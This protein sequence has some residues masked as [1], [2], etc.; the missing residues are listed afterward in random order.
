MGDNDLVFD[1]VGRDIQHG[2]FKGYAD[3]LLFGP[4]GAGKT[5]LASTIVEDPEKLFVI[6]CDPSGHRGI[7]FPAKG[8]LIQSSREVAEIYL[9]FV[10][11]KMTQFDA[12][13][14]DGLSFYHDLLVREIGKLFYEERGATDPDLLTYQGRLKIY[15]KF[16]ETIRCFI[17]LTQ[18]KKSDGSLDIER[19]CHVVFTTL[20]ERVHENESAD[21]IKR[22]LLG[23]RGINEKQPAFFSVQG[24]VQPVGGLNPDGTANLDRKVVFIGGEG[25]VQAKDRLGIFPPICNPMPPLH[26]FFDLGGRD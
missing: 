12:I 16:A 18:L 1:V 5:Y 19:S 26:T 11:G 22:P 9:M 24:Y 21:F 17:G 25:G 3:I 20:E 6:A 10:Q 2:K 14:F 7:P 4:T 15:N 8:K 13:L 23:T